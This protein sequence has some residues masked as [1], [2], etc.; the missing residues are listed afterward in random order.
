[1]KRQGKLYKFDL[2][3][4]CYSKDSDQAVPT[5]RT[6]RV[7]NIDKVI[8]DGKDTTPKYRNI[9]LHGIGVN[10]PA[11]IYTASGWPSVGGDALKIL[12]GKVSSEFHFMDDDIDDVGDACETVS[13]EYLVKQENMS[14]YVDTSVYG[15]AFEAFK[16]KEK[17]KEACHAIAA[18]CQVCSIDSLI[19]NFILPLQVISAVISH[20]LCLLIS[21]AN[22]FFSSFLLQIYVTLYNDIG[23]LLLQSSNISGKNRRIHCSLNINTET[24]RL[25]A[26]RPNLQV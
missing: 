16:P 1:M 25:S 2:I 8:E 9:T 19:S 5:E 15:T 10:L 4:S 17:G 7:P 21:Q 11:E 22:S 6:F 20:C 3:V 18:L 26:R 14:E 12:S 24:G 13:D 23:F